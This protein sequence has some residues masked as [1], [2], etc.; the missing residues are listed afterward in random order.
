LNEI[1]KLEVGKVMYLIQSKQYPH[2]ISHNF[3]K[4]C[5]YH[6]HITQSLFTLPLVRTL[7]LQQSFL[8]SGC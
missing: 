4:I 8:H 5:Q 2:N 6:S 7:I 1:H 3:T